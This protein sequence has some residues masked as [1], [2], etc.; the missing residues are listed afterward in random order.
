VTETSE[1]Y[2]GVFKRLTGVALEDFSSHDP[3]GAG[4]GAET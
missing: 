3:A 1:R 2:L 4:H